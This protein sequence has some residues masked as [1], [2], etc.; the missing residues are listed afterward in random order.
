M[1]AMWPAREVIF[2]VHRRAPGP[3]GVLDAGGAYPSYRGHGDRVGELRTA[4]QVIGAAFAALGL[5]LGLAAV[6]AH[7]AWAL[8]LAELPAHPRA[9]P[10]IVSTL[11]GVGLLLIGWRRRVAVRNPAQTTAGAGGCMSPSLQKAV[12]G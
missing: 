8:P 4:C 7:L 6:I 2:A 9:L 11:V 5:G 10:A 3:R 1:V 12:C